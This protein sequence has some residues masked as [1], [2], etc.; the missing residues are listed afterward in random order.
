V[1]AS[2]RV[3]AAVDLAAALA[4]PIA[5]RAPEIAGKFKSR[6]KP[7]ALKAPAFSS[8]PAPAAGA[9]R[10]GARG[11]PPEPPTPQAAD[12]GGAVVGT[13]AEGIEVRAPV[14]NPEDELAA[15]QARYQKIMEQMH[16]KR[17]GNNA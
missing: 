4:A 10:A 17:G 12:E 1:P 14:P 7:S 11:A 13:L 16:G 8:P 9:D 5:K 6:S 2:P 15:A 3:A